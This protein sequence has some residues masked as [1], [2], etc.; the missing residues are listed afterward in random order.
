MTDDNSATRETVARTDKHSGATLATR[1][2]DITQALVAAGVTL[3]AV[4]YSAE[5]SIGGIDALDIYG[6][7]AKRLAEGAVP[8]DLLTE[9]LLYFSVLLVRRHPQWC[10]RP[11]SFGVFE[12]QIATGQLRHFHHQRFID[13]T[14]H[15]HEG[16]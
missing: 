4:R 10:S 2:P 6:A 15:L 3:I 16:I 5:N 1:F 13:V 12:W 14:T 9:V 8:E 7:N 11:G